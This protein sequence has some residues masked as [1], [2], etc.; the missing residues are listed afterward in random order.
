MRREYNDFDDFYQ[1]YVQAHRQPWNRRLH[2]VGW[3]AGAS[4][5]SL[6][7]PIAG[8]F[9]VPLGTGLGLAL[10][11]AGHRFVERNESLVFRH[12][13]WTARADL[14]MFRSMMTCSH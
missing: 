4:L 6:A 5:S 8:V 3:I 2:L 1:A 14:R 11:L 10:A 12:P 13:L 7:F 9:A